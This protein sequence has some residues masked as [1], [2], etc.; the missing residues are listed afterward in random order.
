MRMNTKQRFRLA[1]VLVGSMMLAG[2]TLAG[3]V[4]IPTFDRGS[5]KHDGRHT[6]ANNNYL[7]GARELSDFTSSFTELRRSFFIFDFSS[8]TEEATT[9][10]FRVY[11]PPTGFVGPDTFETLELNPIN[12]F[13]ITGFFADDPGTSAFLDLGDGTTPYGSR[14]IQ[15]TDVDAFIDIPLNAAALFDLNFAINHGIPF[16]FGGQLTTVGV[17]VV[18][19]IEQV[20]GSSGSAGG[21]GD[22]SSVLILSGPKIPDVPEPAALSMM[23]SGIAVLG[24]VRRQSARG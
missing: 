5:V 10:V 14:D 6:A 17:S 8:L 4:V 24:L 21:P 16:G 3:T 15:N 9:A 11:N 1:A 18:G 22:G 12:K 2:P 7:T 23:L 13:P 20:F 19:D